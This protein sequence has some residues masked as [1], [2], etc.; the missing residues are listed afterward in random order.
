[1][2]TIWPVVERGGRRKRTKW[3]RE[4]RTQYLLGHDSVRGDMLHFF[5]A[6]AIAL[7]EFVEVLEVLVAQ[8]I[9]D[10]RVQVEVGERVRERGV[11]RHAFRARRHGPASRSG[12]WARRD[13]DEAVDGRR[14]RAVTCCGDIGG[15]RLGLEIHRRRAP[16]G[17]PRD[18][19]GCRRC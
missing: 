6:A 1:M 15:G 4:G 10:L 17:A 13:G 9:L 5:H 8:V 14:A 11:I 12:S 3:K 18:R 7:P 16:L 2:R 19:L